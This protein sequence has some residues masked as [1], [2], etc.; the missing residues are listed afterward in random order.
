MNDRYFLYLNNKIIEPGKKKMATGMSYI[1]LPAMLR[2]T[3]YAFYLFKKIF[4]PIQG[5]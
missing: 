5:C 2:V 4:S 3:K 1:M